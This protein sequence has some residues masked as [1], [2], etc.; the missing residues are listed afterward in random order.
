MTVYFSW[1]VDV[2]LEETQ[3]DRSGNDVTNKGR[4]QRNQSATENKAK[5]GKSQKNNAKTGKSVKTKSH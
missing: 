4:N 2:F 3:W 1:Q 5:T